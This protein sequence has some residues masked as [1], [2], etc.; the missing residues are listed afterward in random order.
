MSTS[1]TPICSEAQLT[2]RRGSVQ[3][4]EVLSGFTTQSCHE[5]SSQ[6]FAFSTTARQLF[7]KQNGRGMKLFKLCNIKQSA[8]MAV[9]LSCVPIRKVLMLLWRGTT[10]QST[11]VSAFLYQLV[12]AITSTN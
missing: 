1:S 5:S 2:R 10:H 12:F 9:V 11:H 8:I 6:S 7:T 3:E 4:K